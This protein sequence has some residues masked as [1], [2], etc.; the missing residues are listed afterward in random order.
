M[1]AGSDSLGSVWEI[2]GQSLHQ[3][4][5]LLAQAGISPLK[6]LQMTTLDGAEFYGRQATAGSVEAGKDA[7]LVLLDLNSIESVQNLHE[8]NAVI[9]GGVY[10]S[11]DDLSSLRKRLLSA[12]HPNSH[13]AKASR[14]GT[15]RR[16]CRLANEDCAVEQTSKF[17]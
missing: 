14:S 11:R 16:T 7:N 8:I 4:F 6:V 2:A 5:D 17:H 12:W 1:L 10:Y 15:D 3:E 9:R 13:D